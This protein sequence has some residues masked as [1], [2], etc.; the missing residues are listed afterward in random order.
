MA[1]LL[2]LLLV[3]FGTGLLGYFEIVSEGRG[4][5]GGESTSPLFAGLVLTTGLLF[6]TVSR[7]EPSE[8]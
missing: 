4:Y 2:G 6:L 8:L 1:R 5:R 3:L 7:K